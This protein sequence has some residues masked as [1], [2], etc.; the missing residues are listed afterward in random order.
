MTE[1][2]QRAIEEKERTEKM[3]AELKAL[4]HDRAVAQNKAQFLSLGYSDELA[5]ASAEALANGDFAVVFENEAKHL[6]SVKTQMKS[7]ILAQ[8]PYPKGG[9]ENHGAM[10]KDDLKKLSPDARYKWAQEHP[11][12]YKLLYS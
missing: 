9:S 11:E 3:E 4:K 1:E 7:D 10:T 12:E 6:E 2:E 5:N 8:T